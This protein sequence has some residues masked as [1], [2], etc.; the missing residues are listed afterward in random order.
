MILPPAN[1]EIPV[2]KF[3]KDAFT[4]ILE[5]KK[6]MHKK[7]QNEAWTQIHR[8]EFLS[9]DIRSLSIIILSVLIKSK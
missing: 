1:S 3:A 8:L 4:Y 7:V 6:V 5:T 9:K 2:H